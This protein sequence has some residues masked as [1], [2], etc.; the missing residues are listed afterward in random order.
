MTIRTISGQS[1]G[2]ATLKKDQPELP[3]DGPSVG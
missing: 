2:G 3:T 1:T